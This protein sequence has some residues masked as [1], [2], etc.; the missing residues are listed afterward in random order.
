MLAIRDHAGVVERANVELEK[1][2]IAPIGP[3]TFHSLR[4][5][6]ASLRCACGDDVAYAASQLGHEDARFTLRVYAQAAKRRERLSC[7]HRLAYDRAIHWA[8]MGTTD[9]EERILVTQEATK[10]PA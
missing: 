6:A 1:D 8:R 9:E 2:G 10:N 7:A 3:I 5:T 4:R